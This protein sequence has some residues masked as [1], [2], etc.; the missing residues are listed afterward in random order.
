MSNKWLSGLIDKE[1]TWVG[2]QLPSTFDK[3]VIP[4]SP[5]FNYAL[6]GKGFVY[7]RVPVF[8]GPESSG[9]SLMAL[10]MIAEMHRQDPEGLAIYITSEYDFSEERALNM[11]VDLNR[12]LIR[13]TNIPEQIFDWIESKVADMCQQGAPYR[14]IVVDS[15]KSIRGPKEMNLSSSENHV[16]GDLSGYLPKAFKLIVDS[17]RK[18]NLLTILIQQVNEE[19]DPLK[20]KQGVK[21]SVPG[22]KAL[23]HFADYMCLFE[24]IERKDSKIFNPGVK[25]YDHEEQ[26]GHRVRVKI[27]KN[28]L[29]SPFRVGEFDLEYKKGIV[30][31]HL[32]VVELAIGLGIVE[33]PTNATYVYKDKKYSGRQSFCDVVK[34]TPEMYNQIYSEVMERGY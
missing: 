12:T 13:K 34:N 10:M 31:Q 7:G 21:W 15:I 16:M 6:G 4:S 11:G 14:I 29:G 26:I 8:Y 27:I 28:R 33:R 22:G 1:N 9:K 3:T 17:V 18:Y 20:Q 25:I 19:M 2:S 23:H 24:R 5:S 30:N 32:E